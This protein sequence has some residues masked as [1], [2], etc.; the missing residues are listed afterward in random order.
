MKKIIYF[1]ANDTSKNSGEGILASK[2]I[3]LLKKKYPNLKMINLNKF[4][5]KKTIFY[6]YISP[7]IGLIYLHIYNLKGYKTSYINYLPIWNI[8]MILLLPK[9]TLL[10]PITGSNLKRNNLYRLLKLL[11]IFIIKKKYKCL[12]FSHDQFKNYFKE[13]TNYLYN[14]LLYNFTN[15]LKKQK[16]RYDIIFYLRKNSNKGNKFL[17]Q[18]INFFSKKYKIAVIGD[19]VESI[20]N[21]KNVY[22]FFNIKRS[23]AKKIISQSKFAVGTKEN[24]L[25]FFTLDCLSF[26]L[27]VFYNKNFKIN[28]SIHTNLLHPINFENY[29]IA[30]NKIKNILKKRNKKY[31]RIDKINYIKYLNYCNF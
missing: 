24:L 23:S 28:R 18:L 11:G 30:I 17:F 1:W 20:K 10:G 9:R 22:I 31:F 19:H 26:N 25:S 2:F 27:D 3:L 29:E 14:F 7:F 21:K 8:I 15:N 12:L 13:N 4:K 5:P 6:N 16:K